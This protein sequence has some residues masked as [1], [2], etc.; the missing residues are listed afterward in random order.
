MATKY[1]V[2]KSSLTHTTGAWN[3]T[4]DSFSTY[5]QAL[6]KLYATMK[7]NTSNANIECVNCVILNEHGQILKN[8]YF[9]RK[10]EETEE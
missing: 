4:S 3:H 2:F 8:E 9:E 5:D 6:T 7:D 10:F 1:F